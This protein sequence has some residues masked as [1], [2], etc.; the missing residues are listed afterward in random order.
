MAFT[1]PCF[2]AIPIKSPGYLVDAKINV[3]Q[4]V[5]IGMVRPNRS[6]EWVLARLECPVTIE[7]GRIRA[8]VELVWPYARMDS[9]VITYILGH[10]HNLGMTVVLNAED[11]GEQEHN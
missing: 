3:G 8:R 11:G 1:V 10:I 4:C 5:L 6:S 7:C 2:Q 9:N